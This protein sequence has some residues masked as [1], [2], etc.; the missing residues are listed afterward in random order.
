MKEPVKSS[1][2][3]RQLAILE[4]H[5]H[6]WLCL[7]VQLDSRGMTVSDYFDATRTGNKQSRMKEWRLPSMKG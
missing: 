1:L 7:S 4:F 2:L 6:F 5:L 3:H